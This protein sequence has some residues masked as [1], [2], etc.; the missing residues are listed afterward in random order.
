MEFQ[1]VKAEEDKAKKA[2]ME[3]K[4]EAITSSKEKLE[5]KMSHL[6]HKKAE[7][8]DI[9][10]ETQKE[11]SFLIEFNT[12]SLFSL[13]SLQLITAISISECLSGFPFA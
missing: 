5:A 1:K 9:M 7:L 8:S 6:K 11:E 2:A 13:F 12:L 10:S 3:H 4:K